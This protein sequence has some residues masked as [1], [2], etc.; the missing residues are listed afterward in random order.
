M[1]ETVGIGVLGCGNTSKAYFDLVPKFR[2]LEIRACAD[3]NRDVAQARAKE[4]KVRVETVHDL[5]IA[6]DIELIVNL[7]LPDAHGMMIREILNH[8]KSVYSEKPLARTLEEGVAMMELAKKHHLQIGCA[9]DTFMGGAWQAARKAIDEGL[10]GRVTGGTCHAMNGGMEAWHP[11]PDVFFKAGGG[12][13]LDLGP[14]YIG[15]LLNL[16]GPV[17]QV[18]AMSSTPRKLRKVECGPRLGE[19]IEVETPTTVHSA[20]M[21]ESGALVSFIAS[22]DVQAH[23]HAPI[24]LYGTE[25]TLFLPDPVFFGGDVVFVSR[26]G[27][28]QVLNHDD[29]PFSR[30]NLTSHGR[31]RANYRAA[32][33]ADMVRA[34]QSNDEFRCTIDRALHAVEVIEAILSAASAGRFVKIEGSAGRPAPLPSAEAKALLLQ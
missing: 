12:P 1:A 10:L 28:R 6:E 29:H 9:P 20:L 24:E 34:L 17:R 27:E 26:N 7:T 25:G 18:A 13:A 5:L 23:A 8:G 2:G 31:Q 15:C 16:I 19:V 11:N 21:F 4:Y 33:L 32:G 30:P 22:W 14:Y 3:L